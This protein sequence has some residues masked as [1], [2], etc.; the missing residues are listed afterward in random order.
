VN[1]NKN[2]DQQ[3]NLMHCGFEDTIVNH[4]LFAKKLERDRYDAM[5]VRHSIEEGV[6]SKRVFTVQSMQHMECLILTFESIDQMKKD[7]RT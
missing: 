3:G 2:E 6:L 5:K 1:A 7:F 4:C